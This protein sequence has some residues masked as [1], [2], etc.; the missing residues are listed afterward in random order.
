M[1]RPDALICPTFFSD[2]RDIEDLVYEFGPH[3][4]RYV[5]KYPRNWSTLLKDKVQSLSPLD[6]KRA[7]QLITSRLKQTLISV[8]EPY[9]EGKPWIE[10]ARHSKMA[11][12]SIRVGDAESPGDFN[13]WRDALGHIRATRRR[14]FKIR[15]SGQAY[16][17]TIF[18]LLQ[19]SP[20]CVLVDRY[21]D[22]LSEPFQNFFKAFIDALK[23]G[24]CLKIAIVTTYAKL[25]S[26]ATDAKRH[27]IEQRLRS[28]YSEQLPADRELLIFFTSKAFLQESLVNP[29]PRYFLTNHGAIKFDQGFML[30][31]TSPL[32]MDVLVVDEHLHADL[33]ERYIKRVVRFPDYAT[34]MARHR[35]SSDP[36]VI[37]I[38]SFNSSK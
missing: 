38:A 36:D 13:I 5:Y 4:G 6:K 10:N 12:A 11:S 22:L 31:P 34:T 32:E 25:T 3:E 26:D 2:A 24:P 15:H 9:A 20:A 19:I 18:P 28:I 29:H 8:N 14:G 1:N 37:R 33:I 35:K 30:D 7:I 27:E 23:G 16:I 21:L 17:E